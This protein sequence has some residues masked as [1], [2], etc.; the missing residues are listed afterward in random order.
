MAARTDA[1][2]TAALGKIYTLVDSNLTDAQRC[3]LANAQR[4]S[5]WLHS[6]QLGSC[7]FHLAEI[8]PVIT[9]QERH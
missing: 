3:A 2:M 8:Q 7:S 1:E 6:E 5:A 9:E 4:L